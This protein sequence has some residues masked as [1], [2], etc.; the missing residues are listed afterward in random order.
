MNES[1]QSSYDLMLHSDMPSST[2]PRLSMTDPEQNAPLLVNNT[3]A[4]NQSW[5]SEVL[6]SEWAWA[7]LHRTKDSIIHK[8]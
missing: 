7:E 1:E 3:T 5:T 2:V 8:R 4:S 6:M